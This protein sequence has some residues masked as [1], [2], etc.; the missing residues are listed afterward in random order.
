MPIIEAPAVERARNSRRDRGARVGTAGTGV[1]RSPTAAGTCWPS[2]WP[3]WLLTAAA[4]N[5][6]ANHMIDPTSGLTAGRVGQA[7]I[8]VLAVALIAA[9]PH[10]WPRFRP[11]T[12]PR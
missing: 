10:L 7:V 11:T 12:M 6:Y 5:G 8:T 4:A 3:A 9:I 2:R 1:P